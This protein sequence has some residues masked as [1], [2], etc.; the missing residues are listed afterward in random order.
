MSHRIYI[1]HMVGPEDVSTVTELLINLG[2]G[3]SQVV[4]G[5]VLTD[6]QP[7]ETLRKLFQAHLKAR[8]Y[9]LI[10]DHRAVVCFNVKC[11]LSQLVD[12][13]NFDP[14][15]NI[16]HCI[17]G[18]LH[19]QYHYLSALFSELEKISI[20]KYLIRLKIEKTKRLL[21]EKNVPVSE[22][23]HRLGYSSPAHLSNQFHQLIGISPTAF[24]NNH[25]KND[26][27]RKPDA[28]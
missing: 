1:G 15:K 28:M 16:S 24:R 11:L 20:E 27:S 21:L 25:L 9:H 5:R 19:Y 13:E 22:I 18:E 10:D 26:Q 14:K 23:A 7:D 2:I 3:F 4:P 17:A 12:S 8:D 6:S